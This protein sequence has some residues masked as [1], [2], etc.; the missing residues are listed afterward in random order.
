MVSQC[1]E[2]SGCYPSGS[3]WRIIFVTNLGDCN[4]Q[5]SSDWWMCMNSLPFPS[6]RKEC[7]FRVLGRIR[8]KNAERAHTS[9]LDANG[10][11]FFFIEFTSFW[12]FKVRDQFV[13]GPELCFVIMNLIHRTLCSS[14]F[15][16]VRCVHWTC[17]WWNCNFYSISVKNLHNMNFQ[18][19]SNDCAFG[20]SF[21][22]KIENSSILSTEE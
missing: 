10:S 8:R 6:I 18:N 1:I 9:F 4:C 22:G 11:S 17:T 21:Q 16:H 5:V 20:N 14:G 19:W 3:W 7:S 12:S 15:Y 13:T 2:P